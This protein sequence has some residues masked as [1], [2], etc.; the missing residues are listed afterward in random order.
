M[1]VA[2]E[3]QRQRVRLMAST[4]R[5]TL[6]GLHATIAPLLRARA[7]EAEAGEAVCTRI[8]A[9]Y[10]GWSAR[11]RLILV[12][13][14]VAQGAAR[15]QRPAALLASMAAAASSTLRGARGEPGSPEPL[16][17]GSI[18]AGEEGE[19]G[20]AG[21]EEGEA[22]GATTG[23]ALHDTWH[24][25]EAE[26]QRGQDKA[27]NEKSAEKG[28]AWAPGVAWAELTSSPP[29]RRALEVTGE[30]DAEAGRASR[31]PFAATPGASGSRLSSP[32]GSSLGS[33]LGGRPLSRDRGEGCL[34]LVDMVRAT[35]EGETENLPHTTRVGR[36][37]RVGRR[38][39]D[40]NLGLDLDDGRPE[41]V[42][43]QFR[44]PN[45]HA[46]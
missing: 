37:R 39:I 38:G 33:P 4:T 41:F 35:M 45:D 6:A 25:G 42:A 30:S 20:E 10:R 46:F 1:L 9:A 17:A 21:G 40:V 43:I 31:I 24:P 26:T 5:L 19:T 2:A 34:P 8:Q 29:Y 7:A 12:R 14:Q 18:E 22:G 27:G 3:A 15:R 44:L 28:T 11:R 36:Q 16:S 23:P 32:L 13:A